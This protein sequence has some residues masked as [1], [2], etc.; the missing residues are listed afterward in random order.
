MDSYDDSCMV[1]QCLTTS[2]EARTPPPES[3]LS[4]FLFDMD[5]P[6]NVT[7]LS[8]EGVVSEV[9]TVNIAEARVLARGNWLFIG[10]VVVESEHK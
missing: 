8:H 4:Q 9:F 5:T 1:T 2:A 10:E 7:S 6:E 3:P